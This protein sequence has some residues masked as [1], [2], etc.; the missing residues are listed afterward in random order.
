[1]PGNDRHNWEERAAGW[2][3]RLAIWAAGYLGATSL[4][5]LAIWLLP[6]SLPS[7]LAV[8]I[9]TVIG[10]VFL[11]VC[12]WYLVRHFL[13]Y[14]RHTLSHLLILGYLAG[15]ATVVCLISGLVLT[16]QAAFGT[17]ISYAWDAVHLG[18]TIALIAL[19]VMHVV[20]VAARDQRAMRAGAQAVSGFI[21]AYGKRVA[22]ATAASA[23]LVAAASILYPT[24]EL[25]T[26]LPDDYSYVYG[27]DRP[28]APSLART[29]NNEV[30]DP[31]L[32]SGS[33]T[34]GTSGCHEQIVEEW[35]PSAHRFAAMDLGF[36]KIQMNMAKLNGPE[37]TRYCGGCH[38]PISL[39]SGTKNLFTDTEKLTSLVGYQEGVSCL[40]CHA[41]RQVDVKGNADYVVHK[42]ARYLF[43]IEYQENPSEVT[44]FLRD[45]L[46]R[47][48]PW[49][50]VEDL[51]KRLFKTPE[52][53]AA[54][55][56][57]FI[58]KEINN[59]GW[60]QLQ[61]QYDN[62]RQ[63]HWNKPGDPTKTIECRECHMPLV[64]SRDPAAGDPS[65]YNR[66]PDDRKHRSHRFIAANQMMPE[67]LK[68][69]GW[70]E[71]VELTAK[72]LRGE[73]E[74]PEIAHKWNEGPV[75]TMDLVAPESVRPG[76]KVNLK[77]VLTSNKVGHDFPTGPLD[78]IQAWL[79]VIVKDHS[80]RTIFSTGTV[81]EKG[82]IA[83]GTFMFKAE[84]VDR[85]GNLIDRHNLW[86]MVGVRYRRSLFPGFSDTAQFDFFCPELNPVDKKALP[87]DVSFEWKVPEGAA[88]LLNVRA[89]LKYRK[90]DQYLVNF[91]FGEDSGISSPIVT[92]TEQT[93][94]I[95]VLGRG[96]VAGD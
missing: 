16:W 13:E 91:L 1:M 62:W 96:S 93:A 22:A 37:S 45:F 59:L 39:F 25:Q 36:Q 19:G 50:H 56:K 8:L 83:P 80:G 54:C 18:S 30:I 60:V 48:Y 10:L 27:E 68:L 47:A 76:E 3:S 42:P 53:C 64:D 43:E 74:I 92:M 15:A 23:L 73:Y 20:L 26:K 34:C 7:Q 38:D 31:R 79:E 40:V 24:P 81:D 35:E 11:P 5:G 21:G 14:W 66:S 87:Q 94:T 46:I 6:F 57:Q 55:H 75:V 70:E 85:Y 86:E 72:W 63:S 51:G 78:I 58:D 9:H 88:G 32:L 65:D 17:R 61:N 84:P 49:K 71:Q 95:R 90:M 41:V 69:P 33:L 4:T 12:G 67:L 28:F 52:Y 2:R 44:R 82:F 29:P 89:R 77:L